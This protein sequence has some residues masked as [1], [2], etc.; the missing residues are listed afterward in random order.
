MNKLLLLIALI[1]ISVFSNGDW[2]LV[3]NFVGNQELCAAFPDGNTYNFKKETCSFSWEKWNYVLWI[4]CSNDA[5]ATLEYS[6]SDGQ[7]FSC[8]SITAD[9]WHSLNGNML[10]AKQIYAESFGNKFVLNSASVDGAVLV[11]EY[12]IMNQNSLVETGTWRMRRGN[13]IVQI[14]NREETTHYI[15]KE[16]K[17]DVLY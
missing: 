8:E 7:I 1:P 15:I 5:G 14:S 9:K 6:K 17:R 11:V 3:D 13:A 10:R 12:Q 16:T 4:S 2:A